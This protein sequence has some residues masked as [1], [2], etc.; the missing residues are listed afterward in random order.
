MED[1]LDEAS[2]FPLSNK[3]II[4]KDDI[5]DIINDIRLKLPDEL[6]QANW[7]A[8][9]RQRILSEAQTEADQLLEKAKMQ[10]DGLLDDNEI[11]K[12]ASDKAE[13]ILHNAESKARQM[14]ENSIDYS[15]NL[16]AKLEENVAQISSII[17]SNRKELRNI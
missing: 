2:K 5:L 12:M 3:I 14:K 10:Q 6:N 4:E 13:E 9:E 16:L 8:K 11:V 7:V 15:D 17:D 1:I